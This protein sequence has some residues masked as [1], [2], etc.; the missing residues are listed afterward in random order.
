M[1]P[2]M[3]ETSILP[4]EALATNFVLAVVLLSIFSSVLLAPMATIIS[5]AMFAFE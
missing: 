4:L 3:L 1:F 5:P 2:I